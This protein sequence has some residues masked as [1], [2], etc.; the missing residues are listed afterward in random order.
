MKLHFK[1]D[2]DTG[3]REFILE[4]TGTVLCR[5]T[6]LEEIIKYIDTAKSL[7]E[8]FR[9]TVITGGQLYGH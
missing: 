8:E 5:G 7:V 3:I 6:S 1:H 4:D 2:F 9:S